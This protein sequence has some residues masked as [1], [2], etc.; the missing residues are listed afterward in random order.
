MAYVVY[1]GDLPKGEFSASS[2][3]T[4]VLQQGVSINTFDFED[5]MFPFVYGGDVPNAGWNG[6]E[7]RFC[8]QGSLDSTLVKGSIVLC[9][10]INSG[11]SVLEA[12][13]IGTVMQDGRSQD[14]AFNF[15]LA[16]TSLDL[17]NG[18][19]F[20]YGSGQI[21][22]TKAISPGLLY[23]ANEADYVSFLCGQGYSTKTLRIITGDTS[24]C[25]ASNNGTVWDLNYPSF[26]LLGSSG[27]SLTRVFHRTIT[28]VGSPVSTY[29]ATVTAQGGV[30]VQVDP[31]VLSFKSILQKQSFTLTVT[32][33]IANTVL[34][35]ALVWDDGVHQVRSPI[36]AYPT[37]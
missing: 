31:D 6:S 34:S 3:H 13:G 15:P 25:T 24:T 35:A 16:A 20:A 11:E 18:N 22:P 9:D 30:K 1:M 36:V 19:T 8:N 14:V 10:S 28:N 26:T 29:K 27:E 32:A 21:D 33:T 23:D 7:S 4:S 12:G 2:V 5:K 17:T 37:A